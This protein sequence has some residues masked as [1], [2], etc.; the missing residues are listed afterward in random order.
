M[1]AAM[2]SPILRVV[3]SSLRSARRPSRPIERSLLVYRRTWIIIV[4]GFFEPL[5]YLM[6]IRLGVGALVGDVTVDGQTVDYAMF[7][8]PALMASSAMNGAV[9]DATMNVYE[10]LRYAHVY[11]A[12]LATPLT[13]GDVALGEIGWALIRGQIYATSF[14]VV[15]VAMGLTESPWVIL[16]LPACMLIG[17]AFAAVGMAATTYLRSWSDFEFVPL[18]TMPIFLFSATFYPASE[19]GSIGRLLLQFS[20]LYHGTAL[21]RM[22]SAGVA[23]WSII[24]HVGFLV[25]MSIIG[26][27]AAARRLDHLLLT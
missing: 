19:Y 10:K 9:Y 18:A 26:L 7:V 8:A 5:F 24:G 11:D 17:L 22:A 13:T 16:A 4:S 20:P 25:V 6:S 1:T 23:D 2:P 21:V 15:M 27:L 12:M 14:L 3:P